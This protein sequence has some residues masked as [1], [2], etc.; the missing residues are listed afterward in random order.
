[1]FKLDNYNNT[2]AFSS[3][4]PSI[5]GRWGKPMWVFYVNR[6]QAVSSF[7]VKDKNG[8]VLEFV[9]A[10][11]AYRQ[12][13]LQGFRTFYKIN[14][15]YY[16]PFQNNINEVNETQRFYVEPDKIKLKE[17]SSRHGIESTVTYFTLSGE[18]F[19]ALMRKLQIKN[20]GSSK[21]HIECID[22]LPV[23]IPYGTSDIMLKNVSRLA[24]GWY[25]GVFFTDENSIPVYKLPVEPRD[26]P[27][28]KEVNSAHFYYGFIQNPGN[29][30]RYIIDPDTLFK[31]N[32]DLKYPDNFVNSDKFNIDKNL[33][34]KNKTPSAMGYFTRDIEP[35]DSI[36]YYSAVGHAHKH[37]NTDMYVNR[38]KK[39]GFFESKQDENREIIKSITDDISTR[40]NH[41]ALDKYTRQTYLD[42]VLRGGYPAFLGEDTKELCYIYHR[43]HGDMEREYNNFVILPEYFSQGNGNYR[44]I[45]QNRR[46]DVFF[47]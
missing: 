7:G 11:K 29:S 6:G 10:N 18:R 14:G 35:G 46:S 39:E 45:N 33:R 37:E 47:H 40:S 16:E 12:T 36:T 2:K 20:T 13:S 30:P 28:I 9:A 5:S 17:T 19:P 31:S 38:L 8:A 22:G 26:C 32:L 25:N 42:N 1:M 41:E 27:E 3:F 44:D 4:L 21:I 15:N 24:E 34:G 23:I 43:I